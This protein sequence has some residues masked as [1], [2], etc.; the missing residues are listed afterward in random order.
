MLRTALMVLA[1]SSGD[2]GAIGVL[3]IVLPEANVGRRPV[4]RAT[5]ERPARDES[6]EPSV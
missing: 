1:G 6:G 3:V 2:R 4:S 5:D